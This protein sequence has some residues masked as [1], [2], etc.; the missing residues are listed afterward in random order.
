MPDEGPFGFTHVRPDGNR[1]IEGT[2]SLPA[3]P[4]TRSLDIEPAWIA[5]LAD[6]ESVDW[7][8]VGADG[9]TAGFRS[10]E[11]SIHAIG[12]RP[13][14]LPAGVPPVLADVDGPRLYGPPAT[15]ASV[16][17]HPFPLGEGRA[18]VVGADGDVW[19]WDEGL[20][21]RLSVGALPDA[22]IV[23]AAP[24]TY[25][26][27]GGATDRYGH[28]A[29]AD[30]VEAGSLVVFEVGDELLERSRTEFNGAVVEGIQPLVGTF[31]AGEPLLVVT[32]TDSQDGARV[33]AFDL[34]GARVATGPAIGT[35]FRWRHQLCVAP[36]GPDGSRE[37]AVVKT[38]HIGGVAE[39]YRPRDDRFELVAERTGYSSHAFGTRNLDG[40]LA[41]DLD[42]DGSVELLV[43]TQSRDSLAAVRRT[44]DGTAE[45]WRLPLPGELSTNLAGATTSS[46]RAVVAA[47]TADGRLIVW[48]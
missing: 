5:G 46:G 25:A 27:L 47:G 17:T 8:V 44:T 3:E 12:L 48:G 18:L 32:L 42:G 24:E 9:T 29:L 23:R 43:P 41:A 40:G 36:F 15:E 28:G 7:G 37:L 26:V 35:G 6:G 33:A 21:D 14:A 22:R 45:P 16:L 20:V 39:F 11:G 13:S 19:L 34:D 30:E 1:V 4:I 38:P 31:D 10:G 2:G